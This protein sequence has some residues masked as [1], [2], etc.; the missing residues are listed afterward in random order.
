MLKYFS[1][2]VIFIFTLSNYAQTTI[3]RQSFE[4][5]DDTWDVTF[6]TPPCTIGSDS[7]NYN[8]TLKDI[9]PSDGDQFWGIQDLNGDCG[10]SDFETISLENIDIS[11]FRNTTVS[12]DYNVFGFDNGDDIKYELFFDEISQGEIILVEG[13]SNFTTE[14]WQTE[15][16]I[17]PNNISSVRLIISI[18]QNGQDDYAGIDNIKLTGYPLV[19]CSELMI[20]EYIEGTSSNDHRNNFIEIYNPTNTEVNLEDYNITTFKS[21]NLNP[22]GAIELSGSISA[23][24]NFLIEDEKEILNIDADISTNSTV[25]DFTGDD[26]IAL[27]KGEVIIDLIGLIG[28]SI[29]FAKDI[30]LRRKSHIQNPN[31]QYNENEWDMYGLEDITNINSHVSTCSGAIPEIEIYG[32]SNEII[33]GSTTTNSLNNTYFESIDTNSGNSIVKEFIIKNTGSSILSIS[34]IQLTGNNAGDFTVTGNTSIN[35]SPN[36]SFNFEVIFSPNSQGI[37]TVNLQIDNNDASENPFNFIIQGEGT[38]Y[39]NSPLMITQYYEGEGNNKWIELT[40]ISENPIQEN[41]YYLA[42]YRNE[43]AQSPVGKTPSVKMNIPVLT[44]RQT[45]KIRSNLAEEFPDYAIDGTEINSPVCSFNGDDIIIISTKND[46]TCWENKMDIIGNSAT[47]GENI[48]FV[49]KYGCEEVEPSTGFNMVDWLAYDISEINSATA[50]YNHRIGEHYVG[51]TTFESGTWNNGLPVILRSAVID[52]NYNTE[53]F[54]NFT[55][56][57]LEINENRKLTINANNY[58]TIKNTL[59]VAGNLEILHEGSLVMINDTDVINNG[60]IDVHK[61]TTEIEMYDYTFWSS[62]IEQAEFIIE[63]SESPQDYIL[64]FNTSEFNDSDDDE[65]DDDDPPA[66]QNIEGNMIPGKGYAIMAPFEEPFEDTQSVIYNGTINNGLVKIPVNLS[67]KDNNEDNDW[68]LIGNPYPSAINADTFLDNPVNQALLSG[69]IYFWTHNTPLTGDVYTSD[70]YASYVVNL[71]GIKASENGVIPTGI[72]ASCQGFFVEALQEGEIQ[73][74]NEMRVESGNNNFFK[75]PVSK[76]NDVENQ[77]KIWLNLYNDKG[78]FSQILIGFLEN[79]CEKVESKFDAIRFSGNK[80]I[81]FYSMAEGKKL[82]IQGTKPID[83]NT[84]LKLG[85]SSKIKEK[86]NLKIRI[87]KIEGIIGSQPVLL[88]DKLLN[89]THNLQESEYEFAIDSP[90]QFDERFILKFQNSSLNVENITKESDK[91]IVKTLSDN[92]II[93]TSKNNTIQSIDVYDMLGRNILKQKPNNIEFHLHKGNLQSH[94][95]YILK[96]KLDDDGLH[97][98]KKVLFIP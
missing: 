23:Y 78:A 69:T 3:A 80:F 96:M 41:Q 50:G 88:F 28:D 32:N 60:S 7:W 71:G 11:T 84:E 79:A 61:T 34:N 4:T 92:F 87:D 9:I 20:T 47:W 97:L 12:I 67:S 26:K 14:G 15:T 30:T 82:A 24:G 66:W 73:F 39:T 90:G 58:V 38:G 55:A 42:L 75:Q 16:I 27:R 65:L 5:S 53:N 31:N 18:K 17:I 52:D 56:C 1:V 76:K 2:L 62:P 36:D 74:T 8:S 51:K 25:M 10:S 35:I 85:F 33:D 57:N 95:I 21:D 43:K 6:S 86:I 13:S 29:D 48:S 93:S 22:T 45:L 72:I 54:G 98:T 37:K 77:N 68:N 46:E 94:G 81:S 89:T 44:S 83:E 63:F 91:I 49:R 64:E 19:P 59:S 40:N 70:D